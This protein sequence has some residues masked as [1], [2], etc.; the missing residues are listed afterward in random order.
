MKIVSHTGKYILLNK[1]GTETNNKT[2]KKNP[3]TSTF[4]WGEKSN[5]K[6]GRSQTHVIY[7]YLVFML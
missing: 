6:F 4:D 7:E 2:E 3:N 1:S 5:K